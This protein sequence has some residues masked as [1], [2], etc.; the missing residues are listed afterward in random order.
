MGL[1]LEV[2]FNPVLLDGGQP[3]TFLVQTIILH[4]KKKH[5]PR[6]RLQPRAGRRRFPPHSPSRS[7]V[8]QLIGT[9]GCE[10]LTYFQ[11]LYIYIY[12]HYIYSHY[13]YN[14]YI[15]I[16]IIYI[17]TIYIIIIYIFSI[18]LNMVSSISLVYIYSDSCLV[19]KGHLAGTVWTF[20]LRSSRSTRN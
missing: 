5:L 16:I 10:R 19:Y 13:I 17:I 2:S 6:E 1:S 12:N 8:V 20:L 14:D 3:P 15:Y 9:G 4:P 11:I 7:P 18:T